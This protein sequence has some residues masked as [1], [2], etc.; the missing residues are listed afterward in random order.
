[1]PDEKDVTMPAHYPKEFRDDVVRVAEHRIALGLVPFFFERMRHTR[2]VP[3]SVRRPSGPHSA[4][5]HPAEEDDRPQP[6]T[7]WS[8]AARR[9]RAR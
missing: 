7:G 6:A 5:R 9:R 1:M 3:E 2:E 4:R 8:K